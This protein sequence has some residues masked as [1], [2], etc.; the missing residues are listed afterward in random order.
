MDMLLWVCLL[1]WFAYCAGV[2]TPYVKSHTIGLE[3]LVYYFKNDSRVCMKK[4]QLGGVVREAWH[5][6]GIC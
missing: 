5:F 1:V 6:Q 3:R 4:S 2:S